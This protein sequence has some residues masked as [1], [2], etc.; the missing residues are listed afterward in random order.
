MVKYKSFT[1]CLS[2]DLSIYNEKFLSNKI[3][4][5]WYFWLTSSWCNC[6]KP[7]FFSC[8]SFSTTFDEN[9]YIIYNKTI[10]KSSY[11]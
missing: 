11:W 3:K 6:I 7:I 4:K 5:Y 8:N 1:Y 10:R 9:K 2:N